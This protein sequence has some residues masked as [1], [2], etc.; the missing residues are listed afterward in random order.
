MI[1]SIGKGLT[2][3]GSGTVTWT[4]V[5]NDDT[6]LILQLPCYFVPSSNPRIASL[7]QVLKGYPNESFSM[8]GQRLVLSGHP[9]DPALTVPFNLVTNLPT[10]A[11]VAPLAA[12]QMSSDAD[13][14]PPSNLT[15]LSNNNLT[16]P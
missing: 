9:F 6:H 12:L 5:G 8:N 3:I 11:T 13:I 1:D 10:K 4:L 2:I 16:D 14:A 15:V 7:Q